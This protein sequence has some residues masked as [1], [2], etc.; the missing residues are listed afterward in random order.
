MEDE[1]ALFHRKEGTVGLA[2]VM[3]LWQV[4]SVEEFLSQEFLYYGFFTIAS[5]TYLIS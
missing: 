5:I 2:S 1:G 4:S 3:E